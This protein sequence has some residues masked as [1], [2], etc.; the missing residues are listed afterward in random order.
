MRNLTKYAEDYTSQPFDDIHLKFRR[1]KLIE[2][3]REQKHENILEISCGK[4][5]FF[6]DFTDFKKLMI[7]EPTRAFYDNA[8][9]LLSKNPD[10][11][12][13]VFVFNDYLLS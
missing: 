10:L 2:K 12:S 1:L 8:T 4:R 3:I 7:V 13:K 9:E 6:Q 11:Q 5:P